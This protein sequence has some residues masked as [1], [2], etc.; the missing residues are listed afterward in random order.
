MANFTYQAGSWTKPRRVIAKVEWH[1]GE[2]YPRV[3]FIVTN[4]S[5]PAERVVAFK[6]G[7]CDNGSRKA[8]A[9]SSGRGCRAGRSRPTPCGSNFMRWPTILATFSVATKIACWLDRAPGRDSVRK[10]L[11]KKKPDFPV[12]TGGTGPRLVQQKPASLFRPLISG[13]SSVIVNSA[14]ESKDQGMAS[15]PRR[16]TRSKMLRLRQRKRSPHE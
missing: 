14:E 5:R 7:T 1:A 8:R 13:H 11:L 3:G 12:P 2:L 4:L 16:L 10:G 15:R 9:R 6:R